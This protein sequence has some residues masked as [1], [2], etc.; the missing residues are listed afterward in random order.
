MSKTDIHFFL[1]GGA[2]GM[3][4]HVDLKSDFPGGGIQGEPM[5]LTIN[6]K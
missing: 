5:D 3:Q 6:S 4:N 2:R 1:R